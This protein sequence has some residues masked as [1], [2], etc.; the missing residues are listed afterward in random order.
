MDKALIIRRDGVW[1]MYAIDLRRVIEEG[2]VCWKGSVI[3]DDDDKRISRIIDCCQ[4]TTAETL[5]RKGG[6]QF[7]SAKAFLAKAD[8]PV[9][10][11][12]SSQV[13][14]RIVEAI[15]LAD[16]IGLYIFMDVQPRLPFK[17]SH[18]LRLA[19]KPLSMHP[20]FVKTDEG[21]TYCL[22]VG[23]GIIPMCHRVEII[24]NTPALVLTDDTL[25][26]LDEGLNGNLLKPFLKQE[27]TF[28]PQKLQDQYF[29]TFIMR[30]ARH[31]DI[32]AEGFAVTERHP[33]GLL[34]LVL[35]QDIK[36]DYALNPTF[37]YEDKTFMPNDKAGK[38]VTLQDN[39]S[40]VSIVSI[41]R[42]RQWEESINTELK[43]LHKPKNGT[44]DELTAWLRDNKAAL[45]SMG[46]ETNQHTS[47][48]YY[49]GDVKVEQDVSRL[50]DWFKIHA[51][52]KFDNGVIVPMTALSDYIL[53]GKS[54]YQLPNG[55]WFVI[56]QEWFSRYGA[57]MLFG[58]KDKDGFTIHKTQRIRSLSNLSVLSDPSASS[59]PSP[60][61]RGNAIPDDAVKE[62][63]PLHFKATLRPYQ[64]TGYQ[65]LMA[66]MRDG[67]GCILG[68]DMG[69]G[70]TVQTIAVIEKYVEGTSN[71]T[72]NDLFNTE[73]AR[74]TVRKAKGNGKDK[75]NGKGKDAAPAQ[76]LL[77]SET[78]MSG[79]QP[80]RLPVLV[81]APSSVVYNWR[82]EL[83]RF[84][85]TLTVLTY[86]G[87][88]Q[89]RR[90]KAAY[91]ANTNVVITTY[92]T[93]RNDIDILARH[94]YAIAV[95]DEAQAFKNSNSLLYEA[96]RRVAADFPIALSGTPMENDLGELW[97]LMSVLCPN[98]LGDRDTFNNNFLHPI[99]KDIESKHTAILR[100][101]IKPYFL[102]RLKE[103]VLDSLPER[104]DETILCPMTET[105]QSLYMEEESRMRNLIMEN[106]KARDNMRVLAAINRL[107]QIACSPALIKA[108]NTT[109]ENSQASCL[110]SQSNLQQS[111]LLSQSGKLQALFA[112]LEQLRGTRHKVLIFSEYV[113]FLNLVATE[114]KQ[115]NW[116][117]DMLTGQTKDREQVINHFKQSSS[118]SPTTSQLSPNTHHPS[119]TTQF[120]LISLKAGGVG[121]NLT[122]ADYVFLLDPWWNV[123]A[124]EQA[125]SRAHRIGQHRSVFVYR[126]ITEDTL[127]EKIQTVQD[128]KQSII[129]AVLM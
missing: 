103:D 11:Y 95:F 21:M 91:I 89:E 35:E 2:D 48:H 60:S 40:T 120:F 1:D 107:R 18:R 109:S 67:T 63:L 83:R 59:A 82:E 123:A 50:G 9:R 125:I 96:V 32:E 93:L 106:G 43:A 12:L 23:N 71:D 86:T 108:E 77:F 28:I 84:A 10:K 122:E 102:R 126:L 76:P 14:Q 57:L 55:D 118:L 69:L 24:S 73:A 13:G 45:D 113:S 26:T 30:M 100:T 58:R 36:G 22:T 31:N 64:L 27:T 117:F 119:P 5:Y 101:L 104:Q 15:R 42:D 29:R 66:H 7:S 78:E 74:V 62:A 56:P 121:L 98:L 87:T 52:I 90:Q 72:S 65:W 75:G 128:H 46:A 99:S 19:P 112:R 124:E 81:V 4:W 51:I 85:P 92:A 129:D 105:Q 115:R 116:A 54:E 3:T 110:S 20:R 34:R 127:E 68:D 44:L 70:K 8:K 61:G 17:T 16:S 97:T 49:I 33:Q 111:T 94:H 38:R 6:K 79:K 47:R 37:V 39:G 25:F 114:M 53:N 80:N 41:Y 88:Q